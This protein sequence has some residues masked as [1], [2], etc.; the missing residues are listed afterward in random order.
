M[1]VLLVPHDGGD[2]RSVPTGKKIAKVL[3][4]AIEQ[5]E[6][7]AKE[8]AEDK[9][10]VARLKREQDMAVRRMKGL[11]I[12]SGDDSDDQEPSPAADGY[13]SAGDPK[14]KGLVRTW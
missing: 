5:S 10:R 9:A 13:S 6:R 8:A 14:R 4:R 3:R 12:L 1:G 2:E 7:E 11:I